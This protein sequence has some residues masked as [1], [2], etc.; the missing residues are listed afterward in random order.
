MKSSLFPRLLGVLGIFAVL[1]AIYW[2]IV[3]F[4]MATQ[5]GLAG[6]LV[7]RLDGDPARIDAYLDEAVAGLVTPGVIALVAAGALASVWLILIERNPPFGD[8]SA[9][10]KRGSWAALFLSALAVAV[11]AFWTQV[12]SAPLAEMLSP[13]LPVT[14]TVTCLVLLAIGYW[15][16]TALF[17]PAS[18]KV[19]VPANPFG[20]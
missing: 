3:K 20:G 9:R 7:A 11:G 18:T 4:G 10:S 12:I 13:S 14:A 6:D 1:A 15:L 17:A 19:G 2:A 16:G 5:S 8:K